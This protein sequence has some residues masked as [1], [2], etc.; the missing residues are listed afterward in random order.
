MIVQAMCSLRAFL[1]HGSTGNILGEPPAG[2][3]ETDLPLAPA[4]AGHPGGMFGQGRWSHGPSYAL[5]L[6]P[7]T[8]A[9]QAAGRSWGRCPS[10]PGEGVGAGS[11]V[12]TRSTSQAERGVA[13]G[14]NRLG[15]A[16]RCVQGRSVQG[17]WCASHMAWPVGEPSAP[18]VSL[19][20]NHQIQ[21]QPPPSPPQKPHL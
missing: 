8:P 7:P 2:A 17:L 18:L 4:G 11:E 13:L 14:C 15:N 21:I 6:P 5:S 9:R 19:K 12:G 16:C 20:I 3:Q 1:P 10:G